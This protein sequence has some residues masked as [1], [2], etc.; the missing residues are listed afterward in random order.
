MCGEKQFQPNS[1]SAGAT[2]AKSDQN[3]YLNLLNSLSA[4]KIGGDD[5]RMQTDAH[6]YA[7]CRSSIKVILILTAETVF[8]IQLWHEKQINEYKITQ[9]F[10]VSRIDSG[11]KTDPKLLLNPF[12]FFYKQEECDKEV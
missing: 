2:E 4:L 10:S 12:F 7:N 5:A 3:E 1:D 11:K 9:I 8:K 6:T